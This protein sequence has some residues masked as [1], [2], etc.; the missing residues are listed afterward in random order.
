MGRGGCRCQRT[1]PC[2]RYRP[3]APE[4]NPVERVWLYLREHCLS[5]RV[6]KDDQ[7]I[8]DAACHA[9]NSL[10]NQPRRPTS[11]TAYPIYLGHNFGDLV[12]GDLCAGSRWACPAWMIYRIGRW[13]GGVRRLYLAWLLLFVR[14]RRMK[15]VLRCC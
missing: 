1:S 5:H 12:S 10:A 13:L 14:S 6:R 9:W 7:S 2:C 3:A 11:F 8:L 15:L 4:L